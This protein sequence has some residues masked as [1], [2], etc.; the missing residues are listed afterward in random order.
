MFTFCSNKFVLTEFRDYTGWKKSFFCFVCKNKKER[1]KMDETSPKNPKRVPTANPTSSK[2]N[3][4]SDEDLS[5]S[6]HVEH[7]QP[8]VFP[9]KKKFQLTFPSKNQRPAKKKG[10]QTKI[11]RILWTE[12]GGPRP[13]LKFLTGKCYRATIPQ[14]NCD[15]WIPSKKGQS[16]PVMRWVARS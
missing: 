2:D 5:Q 3:L 8:M 7:Y 13:L 14:K 11:S 12:R 10:R 6:F 4:R 15:T 1:K 9:P 16:R